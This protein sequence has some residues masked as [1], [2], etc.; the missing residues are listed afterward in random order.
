[1]RVLVFCAVLALVPLTACSTLTIEADTSTQLAGDFRYV[2]TTGDYHGGHIGR[3]AISVEPRLTDSVTATLGI[4]HTSLLDTGR[5]RGQERA[6]MGLRWTP[7]A[8]S[9][10]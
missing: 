6:Y 10:Q 1:M 3:V 9:A 2:G 7:F 5:D 8:R 4:E